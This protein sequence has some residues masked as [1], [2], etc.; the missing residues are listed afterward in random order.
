[1]CKTRFSERTGTPLFDSRL[2]G[3][4][5]NTV[6][7]YGVRAGRDARQLHDELASVTAL[8]RIGHG[9]HRACPGGVEASAQ[10]GRPPFSAPT[11]AS[12]VGA[13]Q[14]G[15]SGSDQEA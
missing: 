6:V 9:P 12:P 8:P 10:E 7:R 4:G 5:K 2:I 1:M 15:Q 13:V 11:G 3:V 14:R